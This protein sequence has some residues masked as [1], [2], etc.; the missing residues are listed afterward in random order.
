MLFP[1][2]IAHHGTRLAAAA[3]ISTVREPNILPLSIGLHCSVDLCCR[4]F[5]LHCS[6]DSTAEDCYAP[7]N[8]RVRAAYIEGRKGTDA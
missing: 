7:L 8:L 6:V 3:S 1:A 5:D 2:D 4:S